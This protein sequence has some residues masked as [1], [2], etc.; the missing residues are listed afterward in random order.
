MTGNGKA[1]P[2]GGRPVR[3]VPWALVLGAAAALGVLFTRLLD[4]AGIPWFACPFHDLTGFPCPTCGGMR[5]LAALGAADFS[6]ALRWNPMVALTAAGLLLAAVASLIRRWVRRRPLPLPS[7]PRL[8]RALFLLFAAA[9]IV[10]W[11][12][13]IAVLH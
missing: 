5:A 6:A 4:A 10:N 12:Y 11:A 7:S 13:L 3:P 1:A 8:R 2:S 9:W